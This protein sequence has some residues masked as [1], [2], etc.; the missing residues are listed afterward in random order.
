MTKRIILL[1]Q[2]YDPEPIYKG[3]LFAEK[4]NELGYDVEV[5][6]GFPN[7]PG[8]KIYDG[9]TIRPLKRERTNG[10]DISR[11]P[12]YPSH[13]RSRIGRVLNY[14]S[15]AFSAFVYL[16]FFARRADLVYVYH[17][18]VTVGLAAAMA[19][20][21][22]RAPIVLDVHDLWPDT[23]PASGMISSPRIL[24]IIDYFC[25][26]LYR[27][28][29]HI[30]LHT[31]G[32]RKKLRDR[33]VP[34]EKMT[35]IIGWA[36]ESIREVPAVSPSHS[37]TDDLP[38][39]KV[40]FAGNM[41]SAQALGSILD[42][43]QIL[44]DRNAAHK[45]HFSFLGAGLELD[46]LKAK[47][48]DFGL[49]NVVFLPRVAPSEVGSYMKAADCLL[50]HLRD[51]PLFAITMPSKIQSYLLAGKPILVAMHGEAAELV[52]HAGAGVISPPEDAE[53]I[54]SAVLQ[55]AEMSDQERELMGKAGQ[56]FYWREMSMD[57]GV[58]KFADV[59]TNV[60]RK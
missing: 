17:P 32:I 20:F 28:S 33:G 41:G 55:I 18:P 43:A 39:I 14:L 26:W 27:R 15:F 21:F 16:L 13:D 44:K 48:K 54:A 59:F 47:A 42:A 34:E 51:N 60:L 38:G 35:T 7:Y 25:N 10:I 45:A 56:D 8:G 2:F 57:N 23:L 11:L 53:R 4:L 24:R 30:I 19:H 58:A 49:T 40:L 50:V 1:M 3:Q 29:A 37:T 36:N 31:N 52:Q 22:R 46:K 9:Y 12:L 6:T 5:V